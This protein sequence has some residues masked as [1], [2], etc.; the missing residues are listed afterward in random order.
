[1]PAETTYTS[2]TQDFVREVCSSNKD[3]Q[4]AVILI[5]SVARST[6]TSQSDLDLLIVGDQLPVVERQPDRLHVQRLTT[7]QFMERLRAGDDFAA[8]CVRYGVPIMASKPWLDIVASPEA[9]IWPDWHK[10]IG[11]AARRLTL[12]AA[13]LETGDIPAAGEEMLYAASH[14]ARAILLK[15]KIFPLSR[16]EIISQLR[17]AG[18]E[19]L[20]KVVQDLS[21]EAPAKGALKRDLLYIKR[22]LIF[23]DRKGYS[24]FVQSRQRRLHTKKYRPSGLATAGNGRRGVIKI[25]EIVP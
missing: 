13:L 15:N 1:V 2:L 22:L 17:E 16:P 18:H 24:E 25:S 5:G 14:T 19:R 6:H 23:I 7:Q 12:A 10:K 11:H 21:Y 8:W 3:V 4:I 9:A 20:A